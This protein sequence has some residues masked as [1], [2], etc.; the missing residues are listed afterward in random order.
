MR[1]VSKTIEGR[2]G[3]NSCNDRY[4]LLV[5]DLWKHEGFHCGESLEVMYDGKWVFTRME[6]SWDENGGH[7]YLVDTPYYGNLEYVRAR[8]RG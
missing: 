8:I 2:L 4:G 6:M 7:W 3:Y 1:G 5:S